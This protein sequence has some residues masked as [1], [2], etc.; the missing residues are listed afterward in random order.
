[1]VSKYSSHVKNSSLQGA[2]MMALAY[3]MMGMKM[4]GRSL[5]RR[6]LVRGSNTAYDTKKMVR[7]AL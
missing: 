5:L 4:E 2:I 7:V 3:M 1:M 6:M